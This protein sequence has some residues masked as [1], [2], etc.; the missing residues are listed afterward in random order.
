MERWGGGKESRTTFELTAPL[1]LPLCVGARGQ[2]V[3]WLAR[4]RGREGGGEAHKLMTIARETL[5]LYEPSTLFDTHALENK[6]TQASSAPHRTAGFGKVC[7]H[8][9]CCVRRQ[10]D[11]PSGSDIVDGMSA[12][13]YG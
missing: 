10:S 6:Q 1:M 12:R 2:S 8:C 9:V 3:S 11:R 13:T 7:V 5:R 4:R